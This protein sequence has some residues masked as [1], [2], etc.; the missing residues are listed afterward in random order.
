MPK[1]QPKESRSKP[2]RRPPTAIGSGQS[3]SPQGRQPNWEQAITAVN[4][5]LR[6]ALTEGCNEI[7]FERAGS[8]IRICFVVNGAITTRPPIHASLVDAVLH[9]IKRLANLAIPQL[10]GKPGW[11]SIRHR[12]K[13]YDANVTIAPK[14][15][16]ELLTI[17]LAPK[18]SG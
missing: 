1:E 15:S 8:E 13:I 17:K 14:E 16:A 11:F 9:R 10:P 7:L 6:Q 12:A 2:P 4:K 18:C 5:T 3:P